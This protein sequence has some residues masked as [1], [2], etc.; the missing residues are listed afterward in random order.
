M[1]FGGRPLTIHLKILVTHIFTVWIRIT[2]ANQI[3]DTVGNN[4]AVPLAETSVLK[5]HIVAIRRLSLF[6]G[7]FVRMNVI[8]YANKHPPIVLRRLARLTTTVNTW[9]GGLAGTR[10]DGHGG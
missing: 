4:D 3:L 10:R 1:P 9:A 5:L 6:V 8:G 7:R 2:G